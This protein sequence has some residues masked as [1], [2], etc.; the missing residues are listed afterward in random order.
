MPFIQVIELTTSRPDDVEALIR[1]W[2]V[3]TSGR[4]TAQGGT[5]T[6]DRDRPGVYVQI[7]EFPSYEDAM[8]N[9]ELPETATFASR[10]SQLCDGPLGFRNLDV[11][12]VEEM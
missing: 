12:S 5:F 10:L 11:R 7:V 3:Q 1:E 4:R 2:Q 8:A 6:S 9:P